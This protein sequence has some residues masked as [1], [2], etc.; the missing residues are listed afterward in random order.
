MQSKINENLQ[1]R[2][3]MKLIMLVTS[4]AVLGGCASK[5]KMAS[6]DI[7][8][9]AGSTVKFGGHEK[10]LRSGSLKVGDNFNVIAKKTGLEYKKTDKVTIVSIVPSIDTPTCEEQTHI[11]GET[12][13]PANI[14]LITI[15]RDLPF[16]QSR[17]AKEAKLENIRYLSDYKTGNFGTNSGL[18]IE[19]PELLARAVLVLD[20][21]GT[22][23]YMQIVD[24]ITVLPNMNKAFDFAK[25][26]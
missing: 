22:V 4:L 1:L 6:S 25:S 21:A 18:M 24:E 5:E 9:K 10:N 11:L 15:S 16:A 2:I 19:G 26:L 17:F 8:V 3:I 20:S 14:K 7:G 13:L 12:K 23:K